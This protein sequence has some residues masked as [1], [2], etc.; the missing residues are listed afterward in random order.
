MTFKLRH[1]FLHVVT[2][3]MLKNQFSTTWIRMNA[4]FL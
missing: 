2:F 1:A 3:R 4:L